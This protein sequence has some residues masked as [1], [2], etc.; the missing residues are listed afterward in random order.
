MPLHGKLILI[1]RPKEQASGMMED[2]EHRGGRAEVFPAIRIVPPETWEGCDAALARMDTYD[3]LA[4]GSTNAVR[5]FCDRMNVRG[6]DPAKLGEREVFAV[7]PA[8]ARALQDRRVQVSF[9]PS[10]PEA[11]VLVHEL[12]RSPLFGKRMLIPRG[13]I[14]RD[15][16]PDGMRQLGLVVDVVVVYRTVAPEKDELDALKRRLRG[17]QVDAIVFASPSAVHNVWSRF[18]REEVEEITH[19]VVVAAIGP[20]TAAA[21]RALSIPVAVTGGEAG[22]EG[23]VVGLET[24]LR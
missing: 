8:T 19:H 21:L 22:L 1:T 23:V 17:G 9:V 3:C 14:A 7:G 4:F 6:L 2:I 10:R 20:V 18:T 16:L 5:Y 24:I 11:E 15:T 12:G 13:D